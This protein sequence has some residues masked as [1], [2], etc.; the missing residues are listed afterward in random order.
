MLLP[1]GCSRSIL[2][3]KFLN[4]TG[5]IY[6][7]MSNITIKAYHIFAAFLSTLMVLSS[8]EKIDM[9][10]ESEYIEDEIS[11]SDG[12][13]RSLK[14]VATSN[15]T[16]QL[17]YPITIYAFDANGKN[18]AEAV[19]TNS[20]NSSATFT[21][22]SGKYYITAISKNSTYPD[23]G[24]VETQDTPISMPESGYASSPFMLGAANLYL[25]SGNQTANIILGY[26]QA[27]VNVS[28]HD[29]PNDITSVSVSIG[30]TYTDMTLSGELS[31]K[32]VVT[33]PCSKTGTTWTTNT[34]YTLP[35]QSS[36]TVLTITLKSSA[37]EISYSYTYN[38]SLKAATPYVF[39][40]SYAAASTTEPDITLNTTLSAGEWSDTVN[41][42]FTFGPGSNN[43][44]SGS[45]TPSGSDSETQYATSFPEDGD[46]WEGH[47]VA[48][49]EESSN[50]CEILLISLQEWYDLYSA[51]HAT[52]NTM[53]QDKANVYTEKGLSGWAIPDEDEARMLSSLYSDDENFKYL[54][55]QFEKC[56][57]ATMYKVL[58][59][60]NVRYLCANGFKT[61]SFSNTTISTAGA[62]TKYHLR[63]VK[64]ITLKKQ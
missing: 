13:T 57:G 18:K 53:S 17:T 9:T 44:D 64:R 25:S 42:D 58:D 37:N 52:E 41:D 22:P 24:K 55:S 1:H 8:C 45:N 26:R 2:F 31:G 20:N 11:S 63:L 50:S 10:S 34:F 7:K 33:V 16:T 30:N 32:K 12:V 60:S 48:V 19:I 46:I 38:G 6:Q 43:Q 59:S 4:S 14:V 28:L 62:K 51:Y 35:T 56:G 39:N 61:Y 21:L 49:A 27:S 47:V 29:V 3:I 23:L 54:N 40:G 36:Q 15:E 5:L